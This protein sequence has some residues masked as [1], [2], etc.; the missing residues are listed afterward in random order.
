[1]DNP[2]DALSESSKEGILTLSI[3]LLIYA[4]IGS[5]IDQ[6]K[7]CIGHE[8]GIILL[9]GGVTSFIM[10][11][12]GHRFTNLISI[13]DD[14]FFIGCLPLIVFANGFNMKRKMFFQNISNILNFGLFGTFLSFII[15]TFLTKLAFKIFD[16]QYTSKDGQ[17][18][19]IEM[20]TTEIL[21]LC[22][23]LSSS[24]I[25]IASSSLNYGDYPKLN[26]II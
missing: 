3:V 20:S 12:L 13:N 22:S 21:F 14:I 6:K 16:F 11:K 1:M 18:Y 17:T 24:D 5:F 4:L 23:I 19:K 8:T 2:A 7:P 26:A 15:Y 25:V 9:L 10:D